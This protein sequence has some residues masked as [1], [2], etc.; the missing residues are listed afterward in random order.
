VGIF[1]EKCSKEKNYVSVKQKIIQRMSLGGSAHYHTTN[2]QILYL[3]FCSLLGCLSTVAM[4]LISFSWWLMDGIVE[5][6]LTCMKII[7]SFIVAL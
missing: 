6:P 3:I 7:F 4:F 2:K 5:V 1:V